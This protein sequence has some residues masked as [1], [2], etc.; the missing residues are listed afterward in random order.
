MRN[1]MPSMNLRCTR[2]FTLTELIIVVAIIGILA[3]IGY[4][5][6]NNHVRK[7]KR[8]EAKAKMLTAAQ[9]QERAYT[10]NGTYVA[11]LA[12]LFGLAGGTPVYSAENNEV[13][14][15]YL[16]TVA[17][18]AGGIN[19]GYTLTAAPNGSFTDPDCGSLTLTSA[20][21]KGSSGTLPV[22]RC[23]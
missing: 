19:A 5:S 8:A 13:S 17:P 18:A 20:G 15:A 16:I 12:P 4:P 2:G 21:V 23:W 1:D 22:N 11:D 14:S 10:D 6:Y 9:R 7:G 3:G